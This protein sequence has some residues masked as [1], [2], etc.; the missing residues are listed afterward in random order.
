[1]DNTVNENQDTIDKITTELGLEETQTVALYNDRVKTFKGID[2]IDD[3]LIHFIALRDY[4]TENFQITP[5]N[6]ELT[7]YEFYNKIL[8]ELGNITQE[9]KSEIAN[10]MSR[11]A[12]EKLNK[13]SDLIPNILNQISGLVIILSRILNAKFKDWSS[14][15][16]NTDLSDLIDASKENL[17]F[18]ISMS[19]ND[20]IQTYKSIFDKNIKPL[21]DIDKKNLRMEEAT[22]VKSSDLNIKNQCKYINLT[23]YVN[24]GNIS[25]NY[26]PNF[27][28]DVD[29]EDYNFE[30]WVTF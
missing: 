16:N 9:H 14:E 3:R 25:N 26:T 7:D 13:V 8:E 27:I 24:R 22:G 2:D 18:Y 17:T 29:D 19:N 30:K 15:I 20:G 21:K 6:K 28:Y 4:A 5:P 12:F 10:K 23:D 1:M 11:D